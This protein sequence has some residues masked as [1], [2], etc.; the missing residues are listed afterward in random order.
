M[1]CVA[2]LGT[3]G[4]RSLDSARDTE[5]IEVP[6]APIILLRA[7]VIVSSFFCVC[8]SALSILKE[9]E[10]EGFFARLEKQ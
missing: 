8:A 10:S 1:I 7:I 6:I 3:Q 5:F 9:L 2:S 4:D